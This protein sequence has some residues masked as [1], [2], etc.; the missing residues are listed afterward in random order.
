MRD[1]VAGQVPEVLRRELY[2]LPA[3]LG[4]CL[5]VLLHHL[6]VLGSLTVWIVVAAVFALRMA[7]IALDWHAP[8]ALTTGDDL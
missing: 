6:G 3:L 5:T 7:S 2:V 4:S 1:V 8:Y